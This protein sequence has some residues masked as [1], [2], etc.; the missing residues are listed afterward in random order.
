MKL[1]KIIGKIGCNIGLFI[2]K[3]G[4]NIFIYFL[5][6]TFPKGKK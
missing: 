4:S 2:H 5:V 1:R 3:L 6:W